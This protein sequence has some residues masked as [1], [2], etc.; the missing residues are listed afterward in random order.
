MPLI[1][2]HKGKQ[3][4][5]KEL[6]YFIPADATSDTYHHMCLHYIVFSNYKL[7]VRRTR[8]E[9]KAE[10]TLAAILGTN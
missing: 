8:E 10:R 7:F 9:R 2:D 6:V 3:A 5:S 1:K 4:K